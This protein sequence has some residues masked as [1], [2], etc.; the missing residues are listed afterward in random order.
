MRKALSLVGATLTPQG[1]GSKQPAANST[2]TKSFLFDRLSFF[3][4]L[5]F[6]VN[7]DGECGASH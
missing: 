3:P 7:I 6:E 1:S 4:V 5:M 2:I